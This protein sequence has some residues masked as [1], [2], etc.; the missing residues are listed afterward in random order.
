MTA[1]AEH[2]QRRPG[3]G[4]SEHH[5]HDRDRFNDATLWQR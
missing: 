3:P 5:Q 2:D 4:Q 1:S